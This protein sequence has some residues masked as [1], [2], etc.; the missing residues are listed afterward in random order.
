MGCGHS[1]AELSLLSSASFPFPLATG[2][3][4]AG[5][6]SDEASAQPGRRA[7]EAAGAAE[8]NGAG[9]CQPNP[10]AAEGESEVGLLP[11]HLAVSSAP[12]RIYFSVSHFALTC[13]S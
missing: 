5:E 3:G 8:A 12:L 6:R 1:P 11:G 10:E 9:H 13:C 2:A 4:E 7:P